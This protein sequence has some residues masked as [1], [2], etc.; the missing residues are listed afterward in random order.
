MASVHRMSLYAWARLFWPM[1]KAV[2]S[3]NRASI[4]RWASEKCQCGV[5]RLQLRSECGC[6]SALEMC[7]DSSIIIAMVDTIETGFQRFNAGAGGVL[8]PAIRLELE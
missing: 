5:G 3:R 4:S 1:V 8:K 7:S 6:I 2:R